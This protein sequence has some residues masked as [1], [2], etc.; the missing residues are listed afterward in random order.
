MNFLAHLY[1]AQGDEDLMLGAFL[2]DFV[3]GQRAF[4]SYRKGIRD[5]ISLHRRIDKFTDQSQQVKSLRRKFPPEFRRYSGIVIDLAFDHELARNWSKYSSC[6]L[7]E[8][9]LEVRDVLSRHASQTPEKLKRF[10][11]YADR[12]GLFAN[13]RHENEMLFSLSGLGRRLK[14]ANPLHRVGEIWP[15]LNQDIHDS[16]VSFF[17]EI[18]SQVAAWR[19]RRSTTTGS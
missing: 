9:D 19:K 18:Q 15:D 7:R 10:M 14:R 3:R 17:P 12:R 6:D 1:L 16:F 13:Y 11:A 4:W 8:F 5:G 2:G